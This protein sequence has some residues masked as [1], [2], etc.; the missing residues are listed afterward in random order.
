MNEFQ[1]Q[2]E[3]QIIN[4]VNAYSNLGQGTWLT[5]FVVASPFNVFSIVVFEFE[6][7]CNELEQSSALL[8]MMSKVSTIDSDTKQVIILKTVLLLSLY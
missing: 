7:L 1:L 4:F 6:T 2:P 5:T 8:G 3:N